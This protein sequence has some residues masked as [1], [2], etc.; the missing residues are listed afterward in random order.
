MPH[1]PSKRGRRRVD[2]RPGEL[3]PNK[4]GD[5]RQSSLRVPPEIT[6]IPRQAQYLFSKTSLRDLGDGGK[7]IVCRL[8]VRVEGGYSRLVLD[9][10][11][12]WRVGHVDHQLHTNAG[13]AFQAEWRERSHRI[14]GEALVLLSKVQGVA[15]GGGS[16]HPLRVQETVEKLALTKVVYEGSGSVMTIPFAGFGP[17]LTTP[18]A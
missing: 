3:L 7:G 8:R 12:N 15:P 16:E 13:Q 4:S 11:A 9:Q 10:A 18:M 5:T 14:A 1:E 17:K 2:K 6:D